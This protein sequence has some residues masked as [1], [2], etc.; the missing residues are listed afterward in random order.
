MTHINP[1][2]T[3]AKW[4]A[5][6]GYPYLYPENTRI[7]IDAALALGAL[8]FECD[9]QFTADGE[10][11]LFHDVD[12]KRITGHKGKLHEQRWET[13]QH[14]AVGEPSRLGRRYESIL[15]SHLSEVVGLL[16]QYPQA[17]AFIELKPESLPLHSVAYCVDKI[18][19]TLAAVKNQWQL[20][21][22]AEVALRYAREQYDL[23]IGWVMEKYNSAFL[24]TLEELQPDIA[25]CNIRKLPPPENLLQGKWQW[26]AYVIN[27]EETLQHSE[28]YALAY[29]E[30][31]NIGGWLA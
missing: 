21:S 2:S 17:Y 5:H 7:G 11:V 14:F 3:A 9:V 20:I 22:Y 1:K 25:I 15:I 4:V 31:D 26:M 10:P 27:D 29:R 23:P 16:K 28:S 6:R 18:V 12:M 30:T 13:L 8:A 24:A 19:E